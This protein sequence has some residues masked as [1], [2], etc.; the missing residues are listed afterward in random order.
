MNFSAKLPNYTCNAIALFDFI[1]WIGIAGSKMVARLSGSRFCQVIQF[2]FTKWLEASQL[3][4]AKNCKMGVG[5]LTLGWFFFVPHPEI[6][7]RPICLEEAQQQQLGRLK[8]CSWWGL[9]SFLRKKECTRQQCSSGENHALASTTNAAH[10]V[11][12]VEFT[13]P[14]YSSSCIHGFKVTAAT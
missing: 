9:K 12:G 4:P 11:V 7:N 13:T 8:L 2:L 10:N 5:T 3:K 6:A 1:F 14:D